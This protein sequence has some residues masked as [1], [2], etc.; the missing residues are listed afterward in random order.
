MAELKKILGRKLLLFSVIVFLTPFFPAE[1]FSAPCAAAGSGGCYVKLVYPKYLYVTKLKGEDGTPIHQLY[2]A[3]PPFQIEYANDKVPNIPGIENAGLIW[4]PKE[5]VGKQVDLIIA[6]HGWRSFTLPEVNMWLKPPWQNEKQKNLEA[7]V[8]KHLDTGA[9]EPIVIAAPLYD[10]G[11]DE[12]V[13]DRSDVY[14]TTGLINAIKAALSKEG[15][16][17]GF[18]RVSVIG[19]SNANCGGGLARTAAELV[20][21]NLYLYMAADGTCGDNED[22]SFFKKNKAVGYSWNVF[23]IVKKQGGILFHLHQNKTDKNA[24]GEIKAEQSGGDDPDVVNNDRYLETWKSND[25]KIFTYQLTTGAGAYGVYGHTYAPN[26]L[27]DEVLP[28]FFGKDSYDPNAA[29][30]AAGSGNQN[31]ADGA[32]AIDDL[33][34][35]YDEKKLT[36]SELQK[37][38]QKPM[39]KIKIPGLDF[40]D[41][42]LKN[43]ERT[44]ENGTYAYIPFLGEY[45]TAVYKYAIVIIGVIAVIMLIIAGLQWMLP[46]GESE[47]ISSAKKKIEQAIIGLTI[48]VTSYSILYTINPELVRFRSLRVRLVSPVAFGGTPKYAEEEVINSIS[49]K[50][51]YDNF[52]P[53]FQLGQKIPRKT[54]EMFGLGKKGEISVNEKVAEAFTKASSEILASTDPEVKGYVQYIRDYSEKKVP[55][56]TGVQNGEGAVS[57]DI[58]PFGFGKLRK[59]NK[60][61]DCLTC[62]MHT[63]GMAVDIMTRS[64]WDIKWND[65][66]RGDPAGPYCEKYRDT[67][68]KMKSGLY[69]ANLVNDPYQMFVRLD[70]KITSCFNRFDEGNNPYTSIPK[71]FADIFIKNGFKWLGAGKRLRT[72]SMHFEYVGVCANTKGNLDLVEMI[73]SNSGKNGFCCHLPPVNNPVGDPIENIKYSVNSEDD[74]IFIGGQ[75]AEPTGFCPGTTAATEIC[76]LQTDGQKYTLPS[77]GECIAANGTFESIG[78]CQ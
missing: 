1:T 36:D 37:F 73:G 8:R 69:G 47:N 70:K 4:Y 41:I 67:L 2:S 20:G 50:C 44:D 57:D 22:N 74:C 40:S 53:G 54:V 33:F 29:P 19:H 34:R 55:D 21:Y 3:K 77:A 62:D 52:F 5:A 23:D 71:G 26:Y 38:L 45:I 31:P 64:N 24:V 49:S 25:G 60:I 14:S 12:T 72:D 6:L 16:N 9:T 66:K 27:L 58:G 76:C 43:L 63:L 13:W 65:S 30:P 15:V 48:A 39:P 59:E 18:K 75:Y 68:Q 28:R 10:K 56:L 32:S 61:T 46:G 11:P 78:A 42:T 17:I 7:I 51:I 35:S